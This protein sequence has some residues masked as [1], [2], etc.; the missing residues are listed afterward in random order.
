LCALRLLDNITLVNQIAYVL[1][2]AAAIYSH[3]LVALVI[4]ALLLF[5]I[6]LRRDLWAMWLRLLGALAVLLLPIIV[7]ML[8]AHGSPLAWVP[9]LN[10]RQL[11]DVLYSLTATKE[12]A[13][14]YLAMWLIA[15]CCA[16]RRSQ[17]AAW[18]Y[19]FTLTWLLVPLIAA[20]A[21]SPI[22]SLWVPRF[23][24]ICIPAATL[25]AA[26]GVMQ[27]MRW[28]RWAGILALLL[29]VITSSSGIRF[30]LRHPQFSVDWRAAIQYLLPQ[31]QPGDQV[32]ID[33]YTRFVF[34]Y[35][36]DIYPQPL[37]P[38]TITA[39]LHELP[40][41]DSSD[42]WLLAPVARNPDDPA[43]GPE[44][45]QRAVS[46]F[47]AASRGRYCALPPQPPGGSVLVWQVRHC[48]PD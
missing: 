22:Q 36:R 25:L 37:P 46:D 17:T 43:S 26:A 9:E 12:R 3:F 1:I 47:V 33:P 4:G 31:L 10:H 38:F 34:E 7:Y 30:Y 2:S 41:K 29:L 40:A 16:V 15:A 20:A 23:F 24:S 11:L 6:F 42:L 18:P 13:L 27:L 14:A 45:A 19:R 32:A 21:L 39:M 44:A 8:H 48:H 5:L 28:S 35:Y